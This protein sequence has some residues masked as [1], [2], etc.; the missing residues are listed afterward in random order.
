M[1]SPTPASP[2]RTIVAVLATFAVTVG[3]VAVAGWLLTTFAARSVETTSATY[4]IIGIA[5]LVIAWISVLN[6]GRT[7]GRT[8][9]DAIRDGIGVAAVVIVMDA[10][11]GATAMG[12]EGVIRTASL[13]VG[14]PVVQLVAMQ[15]GGGRA[16]RNG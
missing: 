2:S 6:A 12:R 16:A 14:F 7:P 8:S 1:T 11:F 3:V 5:S 9:F 4:A 10:L 13:L 15:F